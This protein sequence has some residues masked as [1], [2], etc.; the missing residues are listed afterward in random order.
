MSG[1]YKVSLEKIIKDFNLQ[2]AYIP[3]TRRRFS[4]PA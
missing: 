1:V 4:F 2:I 3:G